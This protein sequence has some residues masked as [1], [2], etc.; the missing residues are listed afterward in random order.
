[1][2]S[3]TT[4]RLPALPA[5]ALEGLLDRS[6]ALVYV[7]DALE[8]VVTV[9]R[10]L[11]DRLDYPAAE[12]AELRTFARL[13]YPD[14][15]VRDPILAAHRA[16]LTGKTM[17]E[18]ESALTTRQGDV[19]T[20][21]W[22]ASLHGEGE[23]RVL[24]CVGEDVTDRRKL[25]QWVRLQNALLERVP[26]AIV[27]SDL[28]GRILHW[29]GAA[30]RLLGYTPRDALERP[31][32]NLLPIAEARREALAWLDRARNEG[33]LDEVRELRRADGQ[34]L[35]CRVVAS[36]VLGDR[37]QPP[38]IA[39]VVHPPSA[40]TPL[41]DAGAPSESGA[42]SA[43][44][45]R[46]LAQPGAAAL[47]LASPDG[48][49]R[50]WGRGAERLGG[51]GAA[52]ALGK[53]LFD[54][55]LRVDG[56]AW[57]A[58]SSRFSQ[59]GR[60]QQRGVVLRPNGT[61]APV[62][63]DAHALRGPDGAVQL[64]LLLA[65]D[66]TEVEALAAQ[67]LDNKTQALDGVFVDGVVR[68]IQDAC[69]WF[70]PDHR[71]VHARLVPLRDLVRMVNAGAT[72][73]EI[74]GF[75]HRTHMADLDPELDKAMYR[76]GEGIH[77]LRALVDDVTRFTSTDV[78]APG[79]VRVTRELEGARALV[80][81]HFANK[82]S[83]EFVTDD[84]PAARAA[85]GPLLRGLALLLLASVVSCATV[86][87]PSVVVEGHLS[88]GWIVLDVRDNGA[89]YP[90]DVQSHLTDFGY[91]A[92]QPGYAALYLGLARDALR[93]AGGNLEIGTAAGTGARVRV[94]FPAADAAVAVQPSELPR[95]AADRNGR[96]LVVEEDE[97]LREALVRT[98][99][100]AHVPVPYP[101][102]ADA[103]GSTGLGASD[104]S[105]APFDAAVVSFPRPETFGLK[106]LAR[107]VE[108]A[109]ELR[110]NTVVVV[111]PGVKATTRDRLM[112]LG[113]LVVA[114]PVDLTMLRSLL[115]RLVPQPEVI[116]GE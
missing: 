43:P 94:S 14:P 11:L 101:T 55:V 46:L 114:R 45:E 95:H 105:V 42:D 82:V 56:L 80:E 1:M 76:L 61:R 50:L 93:R 40:A 91:L 57:D 24:V 17:R 108:T 16:A 109:P 23:A 12:L 38:A 75:V 84:L 44:L 88:G 64:I 19:R 104:G 4:T 72:V 69:A 67:A 90:V 71:F 30:E 87:S 59:R 89:G 27:V 41:A 18:S 10:A 63:I 21:R 65:T 97:L 100:E 49:V 28:E 110:R 66:L 32:S 25:E 98:I 113:V 73:R 79:P 103:L 83:L 112:D 68:R 20:V 60:L 70:E 13:L 107:F 35:S 7:I 96:V 92:S 9:N 47:V 22:T 15:S 36:R 26:E 51:T 48:I 102:L 34:V 29:T 111:P 62:E 52:R 3:T 78:E 53:R 2:S 106:L 77:R 54:D 6:R 39:L 115:A 31:I 58:A 85:R 5:A 99:D 86:E 74:D 33:P 8:R 37:G 116:V 81:H